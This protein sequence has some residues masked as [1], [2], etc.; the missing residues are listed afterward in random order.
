M[1]QTYAKLLK[2]AGGRDVWG[3]H[4]VHFAQYQGNASYVNSGTFATSGEI[5]D[6]IGGQTE[7]GAANTPLRGIDAIPDVNTVS[8]TYLIRFFPQAAG[9]AGKP[10]GR[11]RRWFAHWYVISTGAEVANAVDLHTEFALVMLI[12]G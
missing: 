8:G 2:Y 1:A 4:G 10:F 7:L 5:I 3:G 12:G 6:S 11:P 9:S